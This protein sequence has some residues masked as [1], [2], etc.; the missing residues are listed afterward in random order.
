V[1]PNLELYPFYK[2]LI[3]G[4]EVVV[5]LKTFPFQIEALTPQKPIFMFLFLR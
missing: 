3:L 4:L 2:S 1:G 5:A